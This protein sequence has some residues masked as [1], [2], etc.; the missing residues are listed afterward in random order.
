ME[1]IEPFFPSEILTFLMKENL[2]IFQIIFEENDN[3]TNDSRVIFDAINSL[4]LLKCYC[5]LYAKKRR[6][7]DKLLRFSYKGKRMF[8]RDTRGETPKTWCI[9]DNDVIM[10]HHQCDSNRENMINTSNQKIY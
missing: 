5:N 3:E 8:S 9:R 6:I 1:V 2:E 4:C 7:S 10:V